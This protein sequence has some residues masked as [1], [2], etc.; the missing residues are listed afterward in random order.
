MKT[1]F[2]QAYFHINTSLFG[3]G[4][5]SVGDVY[6]KNPNDGSY[7]D[8][9]S[10]TSFPDKYIIGQVDMTG[11]SKETLV[12]KDRVETVVQ[13]VYRD[14]VKHKVT[15]TG[16]DATI[17][18]E[19]SVNINVVSQDLMPE[20]FI[21]AE[22]KATSEINTVGKIIDHLMS[23]ININMNF[24][25]V[26]ATSSGSSL[27]LESIK[28]DNLFVVNS[29]VDGVGATIVTV[30][31]DNGVGSI[32]EMRE[33]EK[34]SLFGF[35]AYQ[36]NFLP[37]QV[38]LLIDSKPTTVTGFDIVMLSIKED[39]DRNI[40]QRSVY[41]LLLAFPDGALAGNVGGAINFPDLMK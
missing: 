36:R 22:V 18:K 23:R 34:N 9:T 17:G 33:Y 12:F 24:T 4:T 25:G 37:S 27:I 20:P 41:N 6:F 30:K 32:D 19:N 8:I 3:S 21:S 15:I 2:N 16:F 40:K 14:P 29:T 13:K 11:K 35:G 10:P 1:L 28:P 31:G 7:I 39:N 5:P 26:K 38:V